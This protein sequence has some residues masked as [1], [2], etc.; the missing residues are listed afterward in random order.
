MKSVR[1]ALFVI[2]AVLALF[3]ASACLS[4]SDGSGLNP[5]PLPP[6]TG[7][8]APPENPPQGGAAGAFGNGDKSSGGSSGSDTTTPA[9]AAAADAGAPDGSK[10]RYEIRYR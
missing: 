2:L 4:E 9:P 10:I 3:G 6:A 8:P 1:L 5:Q 7:E